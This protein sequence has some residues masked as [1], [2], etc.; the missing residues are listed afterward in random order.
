MESVDLG[1]EVLIDLSLIRDPY[2]RL[3]VAANGEAVASGSPWVA[4]SKCVAGLCWVPSRQAI[5]P[6]PR[7]PARGRVRHQG[8]QPRR[9]PLRAW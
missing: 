8:R 4:V 7:P 6:H 3:M 1:S 9:Q 2:V 5:P